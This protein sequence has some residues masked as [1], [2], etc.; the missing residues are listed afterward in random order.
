MVEI[1]Y[2]VV[3]E[4]PDFLLVYKKPGVSFHSESGEPGLFEAI[5]QGQG[6]SQLYPVH[7][8]DKITSGLLV[9]AKTAEANRELC[10]QF[11]RRQAQKFYLALSAKKPGKKQGLIKGDMQPAR[12]GSWMLSKTQE[13]PAATQFFSKGLGDG[14]RL[15][16]LR[17]H[18]GK[19][20][21]LRVAM[22]S[23]GA[24]ILGDSLYGGEAAD[25][26]YLHAYS[27]AF[28]LGQQTYSYTELPREGSE[29]L[30]AGFAAAVL[31]YQ[32][33]WQLPWPAMG[34]C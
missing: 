13:N 11:A 1:F 16:I 24:P 23:L 21:Q 17:P 22:K 29:F 8:L 19:T 33:P 26:G 5:K 12:R 25:R 30:Q 2:Q 10:E 4:Q 27:L 7:R 32:Q 34:N 28:S 15:F 6:Y 31:D 9:L 3:D 20:H 14:R 18:T